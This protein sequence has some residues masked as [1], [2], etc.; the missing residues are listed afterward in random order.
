[1]ANLGASPGLATA[2]GMPGSIRRSSCQTLVSTAAAR[3]ACDDSTEIVELGSV[4]WLVC[5][6]TQT[7]R[8]ENVTASWRFLR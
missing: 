4:T 8:K 5:M 3:V 1:M 6:T 2:A 7:I